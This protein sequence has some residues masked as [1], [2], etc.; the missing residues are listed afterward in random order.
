MT[1]LNLSDGDISLRKEILQ[2]LETAVAYHWAFSYIATVKGRVTSK[3]LSLISIDTE[4][5]TF[6][7]GSELKNS[8]VGAGQPIMF[9]AQSGGLSVVFKSQILEVS[10]DEAAANTLSGCQI[11]I[12]YKI[13][14]TQLRKTA[15]VNL[16]ELA[17]V[18]VIL[19]MTNGSMLEGTVVDISTSGAKFRVDQDLESELRNPK[20][21]DACK[22]S[23]SDDLALQTGAQLIGMTIVKENK[24]SLL[25]CQFVHMKDGDEEMLENFIN[26]NLVAE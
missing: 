6:R 18:P 19:Y 24:V 13:S 16:E 22:I 25:R 9:R 21:I 12:P 10:E 3:S 1:A 2:F 8:N 20:L 23:L 11:Q 7:V 4:E 15:R 14:V 17:Q 5:G 26:K